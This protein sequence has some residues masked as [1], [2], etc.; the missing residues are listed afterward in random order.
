MSGPR[1]IV[2]TLA[3]A[4]AIVTAAPTMAT[5]APVVRERIGWGEAV[6]ID[7]SGPMCWHYN[8]RPNGRRVAVIIGGERAA[9]GA[10][11]RGPRLARF[12]LPRRSHE[13]SITVFATGA[14]VIV[15]V[16]DR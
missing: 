11:C 10:P 7:H 4:L 12:V 15:W 9:R 8:V 16:A 13:D 6:A 14:R 3:I 1:R 2:A 5:A